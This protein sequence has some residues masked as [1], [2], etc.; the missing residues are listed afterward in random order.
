MGRHKW[1]AK[2]EMDYFVLKR[3]TTV[4]KKVIMKLSIMSNC[5]TNHGYVTRVI[6]LPVKDWMT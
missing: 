5:Y 1:G 6:A 3:S 4:N 2:E